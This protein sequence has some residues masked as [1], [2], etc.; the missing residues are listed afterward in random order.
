MKV[1]VVGT[2]GVGAAVAAVAQRRDFFE[3]ITFAD[4][5]PTRPQALVERLDDGRFAAAQVDASDEA[6]VGALAREVDVV[7]NATDPRFNMPIFSAALE[8][9]CTYLDMAM[10]LSGP[11]VL[12]GDAQ[13]AEHERWKE[14]GLLALVGIGVEPGLSDVFARYAAN[15][16]FDEIDEVAVRDGANLAVEGYE[17]APTFSIWTTI[18]ECLNPPLIWERERGFYTTEPFSEPELFD[19]P[20]GIGPVECVN[21]EHEEVVLVPREIECRRVTFKYGLGEE[22][23]GVLRT[24]HKL[25]LDSKEPVSVRGAERRASRHGRG[26]APGSRHPR[27]PHARQDLRGHPR[28]RQGQGRA[29]TRDVPLPRL[30]QRADDARVRHPGRRPANCAE[31]GDRAGTARARD[32]ER[33]GG[34]RPR[35]L[36]RRAVPRVARR[37]RREARPG[38]AGMNES[39]RPA[40]A[41]SARRGPGLWPGVALLLGAGMLVLLLLH[42][43]ID[44]SW[45]NHPAHFWLV[46][47]AASVSVGLGYAVG[48]AARRR[49]DARLF[50]V[51]LAFISAAGFLG[52]HALATP[53]VL[54]GKNAGFEL[55][56]PF[57]LAVAG[58]F[59]AA[60]GLPLRPAAAERV[61]RW[62]WVLIGALALLLAGW[63]A[64]SLSELE[65]LAGELGSEQLDGWQIT[66]AAVGVVLYTTAAVG[67]FRLYRRRREQFLLGVALAFSLLAEAM[68][69]IAWARN[70]RVSWWEWHLL[71]L[72][73][74]VAIAVS[75]RGEWH[76][77]RFS[78]LYLDETLANTREATILFA[79]LQGFTSFSE[80][81]TP[82]QVA[83]MLNGYFGSLVPLLER[84]GGVVHQIIGDAVMVIFNQRGDQPDHAAAAARTALA[85]QAAAAEVAAGHPDWPR[86]RAGVN[87]GEVLAGLVGG[88]SGHRKHGVVGDT[89]NLAARLESA[90]PVGKVVVGPETAAALP[91]GAVLERMTPLELKGKD[92]PVQ[93][94]VLHNL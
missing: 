23:I 82:A 34:S 12:L 65:P 59:A 60:S 89:V 78:P 83:A 25:G 27:R 1:L 43:G 14:A 90:A 77:E 9:R 54:L 4:L 37:V 64:V 79:D 21:V 74:F 40:V 76:E 20:E 17:F 61:L 56:T 57:G 67:Y 39:A 85:F 46:F 31:P 68:L 80:R 75:A 26:R 15:H 19:F 33:R 72:I 84:E 88:A 47:G 92:E 81:T 42:P 66:L 44:E 41:G 7:L 11:G 70:W 69:V 28:H 58:V 71:M 30:R 55:A 32:V 13:F 29:A 51:S 16:L 36:R 86:F 35:G 45:E 6:S 48:V 50:L 22:F 91:P 52:L 53:G 5:D 93:A 62:A 87:T 24:L 10:S 18:E 63:A 8:A 49:R 73:A 38:R 3:R 2:G 94:F